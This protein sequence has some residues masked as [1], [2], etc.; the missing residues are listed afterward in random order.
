MKKKE[1]KTIHIILLIIISILFALSFYFD[2]EYIII[3]TFEGV[4]FY[5]SDGFSNSSSKVVIN[6]IFKLLPL[7]LIFFILIYVFF[8]HFS[9]QY[10]K[11]NNKKKYIFNFF[12]KYKKLVTSLLLVLSIFCLLKSVH[13]FEYVKY[14]YSSSTFIED[15]YVDPKN[16]NINFE[17]K[18]NLIV[19]YTESL[20]T[21]FF[22]K[23]QGGLWDYEVIPELYNL[24]S[25]EDSVSFYNKNYA[26]G[27]NE[28]E[29]ASWTTASIFANSS[30]IPFKV[31]IGK[32]D[33]HPKNFLNGSYTLGDLLKDNGY[34]NELISA[35][36]VSFG[37]IEEYFT[38]HGDYNII[39]EKTLS[40]Y[41]FELKQNNRSGWGFNDRYLFDI[42]KQRLNELSSNDKPFN[43]ELITIDTH[44]YDGYI[45]DYSESKYSN[46]YENV[47]ATD[48]K[49]IVDFVNWVKQQKFYKNTT[50]LI[51][52]DHLSMDGD[53]FHRM[54]KEGKRY[55]Y[56]CIIN[57]YIKKQNNENR[58][59]TALDT[60]PTIV[61]ALGGKIEGN[62]LGLGV[63]LFSSEKTLAEEYGLQ[64]LVTELEK[65]S[66]FYDKKILGQKYNYN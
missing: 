34:Y 56:N 25:E 14:Y 40:K 22:T 66:S 50:I 6:I 18:R 7:V 35:A 2:R 24:L 19:I 52:G 20:E 28:I 65:N 53:F 51:I 47:Y 16:T 15:N 46:Q 30:G 26:E 17:E 32:N 21:S 5:I 55:I 63:N 23:E 49:L 60:Y 43:L 41:G 1:N 64:Y 10:I 38:K 4:L 36:R 27:M 8:Y 39:D 13:F 33:Y 45:G 58:I 11:V 61:S 44:Y 12:I 62:R 48:S 31:R 54:N 37:G 3:K 9:H 59:I 29:G 42:A 57:P